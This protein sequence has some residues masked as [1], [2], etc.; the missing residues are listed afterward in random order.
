MTN[1]D[2]HQQIQDLEKAGWK[3]A[4]PPA[5]A[6]RYAFPNF[7]ETLNFLI[8]MG[9]AAEEAGV[10]PRV[11]IE[12]GTEVDIRVGRPPVEGLS[13]AEINLAQILTS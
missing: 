1:E 10:M 5:L 4:P 8:E 11:Q 9:D 7:T 12:S 3:A 2:M 6:R 13:E